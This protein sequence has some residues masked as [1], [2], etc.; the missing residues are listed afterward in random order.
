MDKTVIEINQ[1]KIH[2]WKWLISYL[3]EHRVEKLILP[4]FLQQALETAPFWNSS[5]CKGAHPLQRL[6]AYFTKLQL[7]WGPVAKARSLV[8]TPALRRKK[9]KKKKVQVQLLAA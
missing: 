6:L 4:H 3:P 7:Y 1:T 5:T 2:Q 8:S 9:K